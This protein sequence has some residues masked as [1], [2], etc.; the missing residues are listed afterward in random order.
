MARE[1]LGH[2]QLPGARR[3]RRPVGH[4]DHQRAGLQDSRPDRRLAAG[5]LRPVRRQRRRRRRVHG[6]R[7]RVH[8]DRRRAHRRRVHA[9]GPA[10][11]RGRDGGDQ[12]GA[13][14]ARAGHHVEPELLRD[15]QG[16]AARRRRDSERQQLRRPRRRRRADGG[17]VVGA[18][19]QARLT[20][21]RRRRV[22]MAVDADSA[23]APLPPAPLVDAWLDHL[24]IE[25]RRS[26][27]TVD[28]YARD[29]EHLRRFAAGAARARSR[30][31][32][33]RRSRPSCA[34]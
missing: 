2:D 33:A 14:E 1:A 13:V 18:R 21:P 19:T 4:H 32:I 24:R 11:A 8:Q 31:S 26:P 23:D 22:V 5:R 27:N 25:R 6:R 15:E 28:S 30:R 17:V 7:R 12:A 9:P 29:L 20:A 3:G 34:S 10:P 16:R